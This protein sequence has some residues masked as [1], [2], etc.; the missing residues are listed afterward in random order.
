MRKSF[1]SC[2]VGLALLTIPGN[3]EARKWTLAE[4]IDYALTN[5]ITLRKTKLN[6]LSAQ[7]DV[8]QSKAAL[9]PS[10]S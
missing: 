6:K 1:I 3:S 4:C 10:L 7:E 5:N 2:I 9:L 8:L